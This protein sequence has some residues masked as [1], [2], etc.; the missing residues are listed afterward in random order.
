M[1][2][3][4]SNVNFKLQKKSFYNNFFETLDPFVTL[5]TDKQTEIFVQGIVTVPYCTLIS[6]RGL[7]MYLL[8]KSS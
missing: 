1:N 6:D 3:V 8:L 5:G 4:Y 7:L 2:K